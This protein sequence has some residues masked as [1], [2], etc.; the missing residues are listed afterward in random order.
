MRETRARIERGA[1]SSSSERP[2]VRPGAAE[3]PT[4]ELDELELEELLPLSRSDVPRGPE[5]KR[6]KVFAPPI[7]REE[8]E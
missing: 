3:K 5:S 4:E 1:T 6:P 7:P 2:T 8:P